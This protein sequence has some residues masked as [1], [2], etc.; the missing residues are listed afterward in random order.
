MTEEVAETPPPPPK[1]TGS[2][3]AEKPAASLRNF[4]KPDKKQ[5][6]NH[7]EKSPTP[8]NDEAP[9]APPEGMSIDF[10]FLQK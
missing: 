3:E 8:V 7:I 10:D 6:A 2:N 5:P 4:R 1:E 9:P